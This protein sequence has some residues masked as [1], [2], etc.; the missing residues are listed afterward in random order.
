MK[1]LSDLSD[2]SRTHKD[3]RTYEP[4]PPELVEQYANVLPDILINTWKESGF[5]SFSRGFLWTVNPNEYRDIIAEFVYEYQVNDLNVVFRTAFGDMIF[6]YRKK[7]Y[8]FSAVTM[9]HSELT[10]ALEAVLEIHLAEREFLNSI[11][12]FNLF[13]QAM[14]KLGEVSVD[15][16]YG[17]FPVLPLGGE[18]DIDNVRKVN[19]RAHLHLLSQTGGGHTQ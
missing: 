17:F 12:F 10:G 2:F 14:K 18:L 1:T 6:A 9:R 4:A 5:Q 16:V 11:F 19:L 3:V 13:K 15:E 8:H 7:L